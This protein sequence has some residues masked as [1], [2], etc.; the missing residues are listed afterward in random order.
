VRLAD[1]PLASEAMQIPASTGGT[2]VELSAHR[3]LHDKA[4]VDSG[5]LGVSPP[6][7]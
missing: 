5:V 1:H 3:Q 4:R 6:L 2:A 7:R